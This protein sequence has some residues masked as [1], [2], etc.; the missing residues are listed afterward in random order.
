MFGGMK[1]IWVDFKNLFLLGSKCWWL[2]GIDVCL[3][4]FKV[5]PEPVGQIQ[6]IIAQTCHIIFEGIFVSSE[7]I[8]LSHNGIFIITR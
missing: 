2:K 4:G 1:I 6:P 3:N 8:N 5:S 7:G